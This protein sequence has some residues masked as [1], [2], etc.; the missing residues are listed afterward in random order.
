MLARLFVS[1]YLSFFMGIPALAGGPVY[2][3]VFDLDWTLFYPLKS[4]SETSVLAGKDSYQMADHAI[5]T[6]TGLYFRGHRVSL[7][8]G[9][10]R[11]RNQALAA[12][13]QTKIQEQGASDFQFYKILNF[14]DL[15]H[16][17][18]VPET[19]SFS[20]RY[21]KD[22]S[23][24]NTDLS[25]VILVDDSD[26][27]AVKGQEKNLFWLGKTYDFKKEYVENHV[28]P[29]AAP[30]FEE[31]KRERNKVRNF[32]EIFSQQTGVLL[33]SKLFAL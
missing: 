10:T 18:D 7:F 30:S 1:V 11:E 15:S 31:W 20:K 33:C 4:P 12:F 19:A 24:I 22:L 13:L 17:P 21:M 3:V 14:D 8:S 5:D 2:D 32:Y 28:D 25:R 16:R 6:L 29:Y 26:G 27:F 23:K 9:G